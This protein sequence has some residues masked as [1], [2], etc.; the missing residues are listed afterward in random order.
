MLKSILKLLRK[1]TALVVATS[2]L[3]DT[4]LALLTAQA[5]K[6]NADAEIFAYT[7]RLKRLRAY[8]QTNAKEPS[9][10]RDTPST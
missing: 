2:A 7:A 6:E 5:N 9:E 8:I 10:V 1:P 4:E 3:A